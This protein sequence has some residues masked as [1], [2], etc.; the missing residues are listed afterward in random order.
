MSRSRSL[1]NRTTMLVL[2]I[3]TLVALVTGGLL[4]MLI[5]LG[6]ISS[7]LM[8]TVWLA[9]IIVGAGI[10]IGAM[11]A[12]FIMQFYIKPLD[13]LIAAT[14]NIA[15]GDFSVRVP[16]RKRISEISNL[17][18]NF[19]LMAK[20][21]EGTEMFRSDFINNFSHEFKTPIVSIRG[22]ARQLKSGDLTEEERRQYTEIIA[23][24]SERLSTMAA[25]V[26]LLSKLEN[27]QLIGEKKPY[28]LDEQLRSC[29]LLFETEWENK[30]IELDIDLDDIIYKGNEEIM[31]HVWINIISNA[32]KYT[33]NDGKISIR[34]KVNERENEISV[35]ISDKGIGMSREVLERIFD[36]FYQ[37]DGSHA[38]NGNGLGLPLVKRILELC[39]GSITVESEI[40]A[41]SVFT[42]NLPI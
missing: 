2:A 8:A 16:E 12:A 21:L 42:V 22:F 35:R 20:E 25:N 4:V 24:E 30:N 26:L 29:V 13:Q 5:W 34:A 3:I 32:I 36:K 9:P 11:L 41:G 40:G 27:Q 19:N 17:I 18:K 6:V 39:D 1:R 7:E 37:G 38:G 10:I 33:D 14:K 31:S 15:D 23:A 28:S